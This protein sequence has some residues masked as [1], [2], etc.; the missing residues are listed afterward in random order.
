MPNKSPVEFLNQH[1]TN[2]LFATLGNITKKSISNALLENF[3]DLIMGETLKP[4]FTFPNENE[5]CMRLGVGRSTL[6][7]TYTALM[8]MGFITRTKAGTTVNNNK[9]IIASVPL[10][11]MLKNSE[12]QDIYEFRNMLETQ[13]A[14]LASKRA[15]EES[16]NT[17]AKIIEDMRVKAAEH[18]IDALAE[19]DVKFHFEIAS[20]VGNTLIKNTLVAVTNEFEHSA[21]TGYCLD[22]SIIEQSI[23]FHQQIYEAIKNHDAELARFKMQAHI[24]NIYYVLQK[25]SLG[26]V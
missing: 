4:G 9:Q 21:Y 14:H 11:Y 22:Q 23:D 20:S 13:C 17:L 12:L 1:M 19:L 25:V 26:N 10:N 3:I 24:K 7:E 15:S 8:A 18:D 2:D 5:M 16:I 6:R